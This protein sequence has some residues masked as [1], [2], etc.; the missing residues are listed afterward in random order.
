MALK[1]RKVNKDVLPKTQQPGRTRQPSE[2]DSLMQ[3]AYEDWQNDP[4]NSWQEVTFDGTEDEFNNLV[5]ELNRAAIYSGYGKSVRGGV[6]DDGNVLSYH[7][8]E[9]GNDTDE[10]VFYFQIRDKRNTGKKGP[11]GPRKNKK[12]G[13]ELRDADG[14]LIELDDDSDSDDSLSDSSNGN[15]ENKTY[16]EEVTELEALVQDA[17]TGKRSRKSN[18]SETEQ[19]RT[20]W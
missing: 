8:D 3:G 17:K 15:G 7:V 4:D 9:D 10:P 12:T 20:G 5:G 1:I 2:F 14:N 13:E 18:V 19:I 16:A 11:R 6:D